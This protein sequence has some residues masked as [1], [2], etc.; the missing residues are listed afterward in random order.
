MDDLRSQN[1]TRY[2][3]QIIS[4]KNTIIINKLDVK[5]KLDVRNFIHA[6]FF[7]SLLLLTVAICCFLAQTLSFKNKY[8]FILFSITLMS[9]LEL[10]PSS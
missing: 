6:I 1:Y 8:K 5:N 2:V 9:V 4:L 3:F 10:N 7:L